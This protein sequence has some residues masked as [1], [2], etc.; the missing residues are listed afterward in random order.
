MVLHQ[1]AKATG[2]FSLPFLALCATIVG[3]SASFYLQMK[4]GRGKQSLLWEIYSSEQWPGCFHQQV[5]EVCLSDRGASTGK[6]ALPLGCPPVLPWTVQPD[7]VGIC[8]AGKTEGKMQQRRL[9]EKSLE[10]K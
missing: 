4:H 1:Q 2:G 9:G 7:A 10:G 8:G 6:D 5:S 3:S